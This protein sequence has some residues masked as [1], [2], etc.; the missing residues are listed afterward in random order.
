[1][2]TFNRPSSANLLRTLELAATPL[3]RVER[4]TVRYGPYRSLTDRLLLADLV[5]N[6]RTGLF[7]STS[8]LNKQLGHASGDGPGYQVIFF[9]LNVAREAAE[10]G[11]Q[12]AIIAR[13]DLPAWDWLV[14]DVEKLDH[15]QQALY[16]D[17]DLTRYPYTLARAHELAVVANF[18]RA[19]L[20]HMLQQSMWRCG[21]P[22]MT[23]YKEA[24]KQWTRRRRR[25]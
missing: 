22:P 2:D 25:R 4:Q 5:P 1:M 15:L 9:Y 24:A 8:A 20:E 14:N 21:I 16:A 13:V 17:C 3:E 23:S 6:Q 19:N 7:A 18:D 10:D 12:R 11:D